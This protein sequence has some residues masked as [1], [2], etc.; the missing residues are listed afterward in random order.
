[1]VPGPVQ[2]PDPG[3]PLPTHASQGVGAGRTNIQVQNP[4]DSSSTA[5]EEAESLPQSRGR[6]TRWL[7]PTCPCPRGL[8]TFG[9]DTGINTQGYGKGNPVSQIPSFLIS[10]P[11]PQR[12]RA[13]THD[14]GGSASPDPRSATLLSTPPWVGGQ[15][16]Q[17]RGGRTDSQERSAAQPGPPPMLASRVDWSPGGEA[18]A[19]R[20]HAG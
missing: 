1:M 19:S 8:W 13:H 14:A 10:P 12:T 15:H 16:P 2:S 18:M 9:A 20:S 6:P 5:T 4:A 3:F 11:L 17:R 7:S